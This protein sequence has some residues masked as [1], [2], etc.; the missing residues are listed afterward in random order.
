M[1]MLQCRVRGGTSRDIPAMASL[2]L[3]ASCEAH[4]F[5]PDTFWHSQR[6][7][8]QEAYLPSAEN[9]IYEQEGDIKGFVSLHEAT[10]AALFVTP[11]SQNQGIGRA[12]LD[13]AKSL[14]PMLELHVYRKNAGAVR[15]YE[16]NGFVIVGESEDTHTGEPEWFMRFG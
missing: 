2:W 11:M 16:V 13:H 15:F 6:S 10:L 9:Y 8:M 14:R 12:L 5:V 7:A 1:T 4:D 3:E